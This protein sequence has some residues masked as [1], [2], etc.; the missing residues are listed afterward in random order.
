MQKWEYTVILAGTR[1]VSVQ[2][3]AK[4]YSAEPGK[5]AELLNKLGEGGWE[6]VTTSTSSAD[7]EFMM[8]LKRRRD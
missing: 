1:L 5:I 2:T 8:I 6:L 7:D 4:S 3:P